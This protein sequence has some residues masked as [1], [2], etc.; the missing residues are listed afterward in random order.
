MLLQCEEI[1]CNDKLAYFEKDGITDEP[2]L[3][4][5]M[6]SGSSRLPF[7]TGRLRYYGPGF[8]VGKIE[9]GG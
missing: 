7:H 3:R 4:V 2:F 1:I 8:P 9:R 5:F 6:V